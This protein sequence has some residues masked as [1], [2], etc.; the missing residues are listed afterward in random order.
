[1]LADI[2]GTLAA[3]LAFSLI[4]LPPGFLAGWASNIFDFRSRLAAEQ[5]LMSL[6]LSAAIS[7][8]LAVLSGRFLSGAGTS[9]LF[10]M[11]ACGSCGIGWKQYRAG[12][13]RFSQPSRATWAALAGVVVWSAV[14][15]ASTADW[16]L[17]N[18]LYQTTAA[19]DHSVRIP[20]VEA[21]SRTGVPPLNPFYGIGKAPALRYY[22]Y[23]YV[24]CAVPMSLFGISARNCF[25][26]SVIWSGFLLASLI[27]V[28]LK[29]FFNETVGLRRKSVIGIS[30]LTVTGLDL[31][32]NLILLR[33]THLVQ[34]DLEW[35]NPNQITSWI[36]SLVWVPH[37][38]AALSAGMVGL[39]MLVTLSEESPIGSRV[40]ASVLA[41][42]AFAST[43][44]LSI[45]VAFT[46]LVFA[47]I[48]VVILLCEK[49]ITDFVTFAAAGGISLLVSMPYLLDLRAPSAPGQQVAG[50]QVAAQQFV[51][52]AIREWPLILPL[53]HHWGIENRVLLDVS[54]IAAILFLY[55]IE[56]GFF[57]CV[58]VSRFK[59][60]LSGDRALSRAQLM[61]W[62]LFGT[63]A[64]V[65]TLL[66]SGAT[67]N[68]DLGFRGTL[69]IQFIL[70]LW[71]APLMD[72]LFFKQGK[73]PGRAWT[74]LLVSTM[75]IGA[76]GTICQI[77]MLRLYT[78]LVD[79]NVLRR[80]EGFM[81][82]SPNMG[83]R[84]YLLR[85]GMSRIDQQ[86]WRS[87]VLQANPSGRNVFL[88]NLYSTHPMAA[89][90]ENCGSTFGGDPEKCREAMPYIAAAFNSPEGIRDWNINR[91]CDAFAV[92]LLVA[93]DADPVWIDRGS[94]VWT[95]KP[96]V[97]NDSLRAFPCG[98]KGHATP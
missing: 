53:L 36:D 73:R 63:S 82:L 44:G 80:S 66:Q 65:V 39:L 94:W 98:S 23:W 97:A 46:L 34:A 86:T 95:T 96:I 7:P 15:I 3:A 89:G 31:I 11:L 20:F 78:P 56:L 84:N 35:W 91:F 88:V 49:R 90:D 9:A 16:Q 58:A 19:F 55:L 30:L 27:P 61:A 33:L 32:P 67:Q 13:Y 68:N 93:T 72:G 2:G 22:Y 41:G 12:Y 71:A 6:A 70:L 64:L 62:V 18:G 92:N 37:H 28:Y 75:V 17:P 83:K 40:W 38:V 42:L 85:D 48:W 14:A 59:S 25:A 50:Q 45:Y 51:S 57:F 43:A 54:R 21:V 47:A 77:A 69:P 74:F 4:F 26:A 52:L 5:W 79:A 60:E 76:L 29:H 24:V 1:M 8:I 81:G 10:L 87:A